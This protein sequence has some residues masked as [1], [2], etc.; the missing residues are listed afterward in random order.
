MSADNCIYI[1]KR[2]DRWY[3]WM[4]FL[5]DEK[6]RPD[7]KDVHFGTPM[8]AQAYAWGWLRGETIVEYGIIYLKEKK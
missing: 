1:Q 6:H 5:S 8:E 4:G 7:K 2:K 3:V